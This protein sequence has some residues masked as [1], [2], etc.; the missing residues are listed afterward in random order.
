MS[1]SDDATRWGGVLL[2]VAAILMAPTLLPQIAAKAAAWLLERNILV[3]SAEAL[4]TLPGLEAGLDLRRIVA[5]IA[6]TIAVG[7]LA[8][9]AR[10]TKRRAAE[11]SE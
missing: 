1:T 10:R 5:T 2:L 8:D 3:P 7:A 11:V 4:W 9:A 6:A